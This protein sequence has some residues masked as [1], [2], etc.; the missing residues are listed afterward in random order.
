MDVFERIAA[1][2]VRGIVKALAEP[3]VV[4]GLRDAWLAF[5]EP[6]IIEAAKSNENDD[7]II[8]HAKN[9]GWSNSTVYADH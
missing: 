6:R 9:D 4:A 2:M 3:G 7:A 8:E 5:K 1:A